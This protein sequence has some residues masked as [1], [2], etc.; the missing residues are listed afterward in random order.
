[1]QRVFYFGLLNKL[2]SRQPAVHHENIQLK[3]EKDVIET[4]PANKDVDGLKEKNLGKLIVGN[5]I[6]NPCT[7]LGFMKLLEHY[8]IETSGKKA[9]VIGRSRLVGMPQVLMLGSKGIDCTV[10]LAHSRTKNLN[11]LIKESEIVV[12]AIGVP[13][14]INS[15][16]VKK[17][18]ILLDV[19]ISSDGKGIQGDVDF[20][21]VDGIAAAVTPMPGGTGPMTVACL[22][23]NTMKAAERQGIIPKDK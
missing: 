22:L 3:N 6:L 19:G 21:D 5:N 16:N 4:I 20:N 12:P 23:E 8:N 14:I 10:T 7:P 13:N 17:G 18:A 9:L 1:M 11:D 2:F 15:K